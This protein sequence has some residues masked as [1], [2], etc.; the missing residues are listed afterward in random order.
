M[1]LKNYIIGKIKS[2]SYIYQYK[3]QSIVLQKLSINFY[4]LKSFLRSSQFACKSCLVATGVD[5]MELG[6]QLG[7]TRA[8]DPYSGDFYF[9]N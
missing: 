5:G 6:I 4:F 2:M 1:I 3:I 9:N 7:I 8:I